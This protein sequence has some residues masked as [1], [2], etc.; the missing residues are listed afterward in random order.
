M[1]YEHLATINECSA[2]AIT[3]ILVNKDWYILID[4][5]HDQDTYHMG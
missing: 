3:M 1:I 2:N 4:I 5:V